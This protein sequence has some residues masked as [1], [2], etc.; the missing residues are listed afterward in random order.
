M[1]G[2]RT[3]AERVLLERSHTVHTI[4]RLRHWVGFRARPIW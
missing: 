4:S 1:W 2:K 3:L